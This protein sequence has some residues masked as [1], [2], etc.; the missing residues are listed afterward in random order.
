MLVASA[1]A[2]E[3]EVDRLVLDQLLWYAREDP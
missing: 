2:A 1:L 3:I